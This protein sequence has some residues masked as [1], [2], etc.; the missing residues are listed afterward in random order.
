MA[1]FLQDF[2]LVIADV[3]LFFL[4]SI[5]CARYNVG[6]CKKYLAFHQPVSILWGKI[7]INSFPTPLK[8]SNRSQAESKFTNWTNAVYSFQPRCEILKY[9]W[10][11]FEP[12]YSM[13]TFLS[14]KNPGDIFF[15]LHGILIRK[16]RHIKPFFQNG[17]QQSIKWA[18]FI[19]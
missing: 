12:Q 19:L 11:N 18:S 7:F 14:G 9:F 10:L 1:L 4:H 3:S 16:L 15:K 6:L 5:Y 17:R 2:N 8:C 13:N